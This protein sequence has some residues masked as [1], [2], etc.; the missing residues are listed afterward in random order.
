M[1]E[2]KREWER[3]RESVQAQRT[4]VTRKKTTV[5]HGRVLQT[6]SKSKACLWDEKAAEGKSSRGRG[7]RE[8]YNT[9]HRP[10]T[11]YSPRVK[12]EN[13]EHSLT[14]KANQAG[15]ISVTEGAEVLTLWKNVSS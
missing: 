4:R 14:S 6:S 9:W 5:N 15:L 3:K 8:A 13:R 1:M 12:E 2:F 7:T 10:K 11:A